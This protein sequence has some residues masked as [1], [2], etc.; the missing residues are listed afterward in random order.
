MRESELTR[1]DMERAN[2][3]DPIEV[4]KPGARCKL[5]IDDE[6]FHGVIT[7]V[8]IFYGDVVKYR[9]AWWASRVRYEAWLHA[10]EVEVVDESEE[11]RFAGFARK[12]EAAIKEVAGKP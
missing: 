11:R 5:A 3:S 1:Q 7:A 2:M 6:E 12:V 10:V 9:C 4:Y 8:G